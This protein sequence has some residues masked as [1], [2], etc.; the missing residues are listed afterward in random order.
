MMQAM[1]YKKIPKVELHRHLEGAL[2]LS[3]VV[4]LASKNGLDVPKDLKSQKEMFLVT[5]PMKD[6]ATVLNKFGLSQSILSSPEVLTRITYEAI[7]DAYNEGIKLLELRYAPTFIQNHHEH[8][9]FTDIH[10][11]ILK[12]LKQ[13]SHLPIGVGLILIIQRTLPLKRAEEVVDFSIEHRDSVLALDIA[14]DEMNFDLPSYSTLLTRARKEG[15]RL[16][17]HA[18]EI[19]GHDSFKNVFSAIE[20]LGAERIGHGLQ[21]IHD[22]TTLNYVTKKKIPLELCPTSNWLTNSVP[23]LKEHPFVL[24]RNKGVRVTI[25][26]DD[27]GIF[28]IDLSNEYRVLHELHGLQIEDFKLINDDAAKVSFLPDT[29]KKQFWQF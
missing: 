2:R 19:S 8:L 12:G 14:D 1:D 7:E 10:E 27:P 20:I 29:V 11:A 13:A 23:S 24:L 26:S 16:T 28:D 9:S 15:L 3:T 21:I 18:G 4:E 25:N 6:L 5:S 22:P 17:I